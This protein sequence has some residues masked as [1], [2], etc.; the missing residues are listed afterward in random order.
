MDECKLKAANGQHGV[1]CD[2]S[3]C[4]FWRVVDQLD[5]IDGMETD[6][7]AIQRFNL[8]GDRGHDIAKWL[9]S[10]KVR[11]DGA[12]S[13]VAASVDLRPADRSRAH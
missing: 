4:T 12:V 13:P 11:C 9:L 7:C 2:G 10:V 1:P 5:L 6:G 3:G 8:L